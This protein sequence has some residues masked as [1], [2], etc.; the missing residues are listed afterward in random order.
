[1]TDQSG[2][3]NSAGK[4]FAGH[5]TTMCET[6]GKSQ[7]DQFKETARALECDEDEAHFK[8]NLRKMVKKPKKDGDITV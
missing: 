3:Y 4:H 8:A 7:I 2:V 6:G 5:G 1:M